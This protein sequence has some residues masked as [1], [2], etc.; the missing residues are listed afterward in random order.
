[1]VEMIK[2]TR[3]GFE[4]GGGAVKSFGKICVDHCG[5]SLASIIH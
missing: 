4:G 3:S 2:G 1:M 5:C